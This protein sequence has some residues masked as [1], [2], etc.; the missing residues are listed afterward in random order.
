MSN[1]SF[2]LI[3]L[4]PGKMFSSI[5]V[6]LLTMNADHVLQDQDPLGQDLQGLPE[7]LHGLSLN[8]AIMFISDSFFKW[9]QEEKMPVSLTSF[10]PS[11]GSPFGPGAPCENKVK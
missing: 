6:F 8:N 3:I 5:S 7:L 10:K 4:R 11:P 1:Y 9:A 2:N